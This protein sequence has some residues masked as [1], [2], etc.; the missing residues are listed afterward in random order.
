MRL[1]VAAGASG[2]GVYPALAVLQ[3]LGSKDVELLWVGGEGGMEHD[4]VTRAGYQLRSL[5]AAGLHG[6]GLLALPGNLWQLARGYLAARHLL[7][8]FR[9]DVLFFTGG[10]VAAPVALAAGRT[11]TLAFVPDIQP[12]FTLRL[13]AR[14]ADAIAVVAEEA[15]AYFRRPERVVV[16]GYPLR[17]EVTRWTRP[18]ALQHFGLEKSLPVLLVFG[19]SKGAQSINRAALAT[20]PQLLAR[21][22]VLHISG[23][24]NWTEVEAARAQL[25]AELAARYHAFPYL[26]DDMGA[27]FAAAD[28]AVC[29]AGASTLGELPH[30]GLPAVLVPIPFKQHLQHVNAGF[31]QARGAAVVLADE[32]MAASLAGT[33]IGLIEDKP[34]LQ[35]LARA[36]AQ[37]AAPQA[38]QH[39]AAQ[40]RQLGGS[41]A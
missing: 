37:L 25:P 30:F 2:G 18:A 9:P 10:F 26:H 41:Q 33:V 23:Q 40:L 6:V 19:G 12:G 38:A 32:D 17:P 15:R 28:L 29:R 20:L 13:I 35:Q 3:E 27:A 14:F 8:E 11:P 16:T 7:A 24:G 4:L 31:L 21:M 22:Q 5:P 36:M 1:L 34:R 39:I